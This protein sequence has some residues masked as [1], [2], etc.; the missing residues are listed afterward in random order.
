[1]FA[2]TTVYRTKGVE[3]AT[4]TGYLSVA[5]QSSLLTSSHAQ[6][7]YNIV[8][9]SETLQPYMTRE[10]LLAPFALVDDSISLEDSETWTGQTQFYSMDVTCSNAA[11][12]K[13][14]SWASDNGC[15]YYVWTL[16]QTLVLIS[17]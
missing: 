16:P 3:M 7:S 11:E 6:S 14:G 2:D 13:N 4:S 5:Q 15:D 1:M 12:T 9:L 17:I 8:W 10:G